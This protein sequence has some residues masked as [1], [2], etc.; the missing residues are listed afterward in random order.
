MVFDNG[1]NYGKD[2]YENDDGG[3]FGHFGLVIPG[4]YKTVASVQESGGVLRFGR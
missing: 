1:H 2:S 3:G 4:V